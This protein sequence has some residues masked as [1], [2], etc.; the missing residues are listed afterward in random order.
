[1]PASGVISITAQIMGSQDMAPGT[2]AEDKLK[3][4]QSF[5]QKVRTA[6][7]GMLKFSNMAKL[8][9]VGVLTQSTL[10]T[11]VIGTVFRLLGALVDLFLAFLI[12]F[13]IDGIKWLVKI[14]KTIWEFLSNIVGTFKAAWNAVWDWLTSI[15]S[16]VKDQFLEALGAIVDLT[17]IE[18]AV[19]GVFFGDGVTDENPIFNEQV[20]DDWSMGRGEGPHLISAEDASGLAEDVDNIIAITGDDE[21]AAEAEEQEPVPWFAQ[22]EEDFAASGVDRLV[23]EEA[24]TE[25]GRLLAP[26]DAITSEDRG[27]W[28]WTDDFRPFDITDAMASITMPVYNM[29]ELLF[30]GGTHNVGG[31]QLIDEIMPQIVAGPPASDED[32]VSILRSGR[33][34]TSTHYTPSE[35]VHNNDTWSAGSSR[36]SY[37]D[38]ENNKLAEIRKIRGG[39]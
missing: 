10:A 36:N 30:W 31:D 25:D 12:P 3:P 13:L 2:S 38:R 26:P 22:T 6:V 5:F 15:A 16:V 32:L 33:L 4:D 23:T 18:Q 11:G 1:M 28:S 19:S 8:G 7:K 27:F 34:G 37:A 20:I 9:L 39:G 24:F 29:A 21:D 35:S 14:V 17:G